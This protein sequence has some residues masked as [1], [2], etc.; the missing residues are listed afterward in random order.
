MLPETIELPFKS[1][2][3]K[4]LLSNDINIKVYHDE[5]ERNY[6]VRKADLEVNSLAFDSTITPKEIHHHIQ[7]LV[8]RGK[9]YRETFGKHYTIT[10]KDYS[11]HYPESEFDA[12]DIKMRSKYDRFEYSDHI[13]F[14]NDWF[15]LDLASLKLKKLNIDSL[16][17][18]QKFI[19]NKLELNKGDFTV[20]EI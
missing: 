12:H 7:S 15:K 5:K 10:A 6:F 11:F 20:F 18:S 1:V 19:L 14:Q 3:I 17:V 2:R 4:Q 8:F 9:N 16:L 13:D